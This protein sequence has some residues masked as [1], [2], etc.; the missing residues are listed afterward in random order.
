MFS[1]R[2]HLP[3]Y[4]HPIFF[5]L[6]RLRFLNNTPVFTQILHFILLLAS[7]PTTETFRLGFDREIEEKGAR[8]TIGKID[9]R[10]RIAICTG[11]Q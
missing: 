10:D 8:S 3:F 4:P 1:W 2:D 7:D 5:H 9:G 11:G 6:S